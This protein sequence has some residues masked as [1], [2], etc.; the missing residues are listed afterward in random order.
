[1]LTIRQGLLCD[2]EVKLLQE[3]PGCLAET[4]VF[5]PQ[6]AGPEHHH[7]KRIM[8][9]QSTGAEPPAEAAKADDAAVSPERE[10]QWYKIP[11]VNS[12]SLRFETSLNDCFGGWHHVWSAL[13]STG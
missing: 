1:M 4:S 7:L 5:W 3:V 8:E 13:P 6:N 10:V 11:E 2:A 9:G 12:L